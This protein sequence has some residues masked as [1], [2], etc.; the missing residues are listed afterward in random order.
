MDLLVER[1]DCCC[2]EGARK[3]RKSIAEKWG[4]AWGGC[5]IQVA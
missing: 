3:V 2:W 1:D 4:A 5:D